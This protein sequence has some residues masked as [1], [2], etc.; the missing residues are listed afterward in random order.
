MKL[1]VATTNAAKFRE[2][3]DALGDAKLEILGLQDFPHVSPV[4][5]TGE[6][7]RE[8][9][10]LKAKGY[11]KQTNIPCIADDGGLVV[12]YLG[13]MPGVHSHRWLDRRDAQ[14]LERPDVQ[15]IRR[16]ASDRELAEAILER[17]EGVP[18][19][20]RAARLGGV[21]A[22]WDGKHLLENENWIHGY[23][24]DRLTGPVAPGFPY[25]AL[26]MIPEFNKSYAELTPEEHRQVN[27]RYK[28]LELLKPHI[29]EHLRSE[30]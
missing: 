1:L 3:C 5:E 14:G 10:V 21:I 30:P 2:A 15:G 13:G 11:F 24:A 7:F 25:R 17:L 27:F 6:T 22:F 12:D 18:R 29:M 28:N 26:L 19:P 9:A 23:I 8:N 4:P 20:E 16:A